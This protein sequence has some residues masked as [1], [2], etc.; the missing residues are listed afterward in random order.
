MLVHAVLTLPD[1]SSV[2]LVPGDLIGRHRAAALRIDDG[3]ISEA[4]ALISLRGGELKLLAL[5]GA[6]ALETRR[7]SE[8]TLAPG[9]R[10]RLASDVSLEVVEVC[11]PD[12][13]LALEGDGLPRQVLPAGGCSLVLDPRPLLVERPE[14]HAAARLW[15]DGEGWRLQVADTEPRALEAGHRFTIGPRT[16]QAVG[17]PIDRAGQRN[18]ALKGKLHA[19]LRLVTHY[20]AME[21][22]REGEPT[23]TIGGIGARILSELVDFG[24]PVEW[25]TLAGQV[26]PDGGDRGMLR[27]KLDVSLSRLRARLRRA[28]VRP[29]L[30][31]S[32]GTGKVA[33][34]LYDG[35]MV[36]NRN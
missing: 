23:L 27:R 4:H 32:D 9:Q 7:V 36:D 20:D 35:D 15:T 34:L 14:P 24:A 30:V 18:T 26:W 3:R 31:R 29:D 19:P 12:E 28:G 11:L 10:I 5:R 6:L 2:E 8:V 25:Q 33:L 22:H 17:V 1:G 16:F 13:V 21:L